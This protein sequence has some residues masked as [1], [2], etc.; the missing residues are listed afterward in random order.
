MKNIKLVALYCDI[1][2]VTIMA[3]FCIL[4]RVKKVSF[5][6]FDGLG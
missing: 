6:F 4:V 5:L 3:N 2:C 1:F